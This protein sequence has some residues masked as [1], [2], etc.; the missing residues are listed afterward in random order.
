MAIDTAIAT[1]AELRSEYLRLAA[2]VQDAQN[3]RKAIEAEIN[4][5]LAAIQAQ[6]RLEPMTAL[7]RDALRTVLQETVTV[8]R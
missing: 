8:T 6:K 4:R 3:T 5:R 7:E 1:M 2:V